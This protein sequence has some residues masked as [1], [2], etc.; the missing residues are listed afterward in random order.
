M[1]SCRVGKL[2]S[3]ARLVCAYLL[4]LVSLH[5]LSHT[6]TLVHLHSVV[7]TLVTHSVLL[8]DTN[9]IFASGD[10]LT[11]KLLCFLAD[12]AFVSLCSCRF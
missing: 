9:G 8:P 3:L 10:I 2:S 12:E 11:W 5:S 6:H 7:D 4:R 1:S